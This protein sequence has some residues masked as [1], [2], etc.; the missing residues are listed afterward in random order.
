MAHL[1]ETW[2]NGV[3]D[4]DV[5]TASAIGPPENTTIKVWKNG[6]LL[7]TYVDTAGYATGN[8]G[9]GLDAGNPTDGANLGWRSYSVSASCPTSGT[10]PAVSIA[11]SPTSANVTASG[12]QTFTATV[13]NS[14]NTSVTWQVNGV[15]GGNSTVGTI[16]ASG[17]YSAPATPP[18]P[19]TVSVKA[20]SNAD[21]T[22]SATASI[23]ITATPAPTTG[24]VR[25]NWVAPSQE[26]DGSALDDLTGFRIYYGTGPNSLTNRIDVTNPSTRSWLISNLARGTWYFSLVAVSASGSESA[27]TTVIAHTF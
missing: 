15:T 6:T 7:L 9:I 16:S 25:I 17:V 22:K 1:K 23:T 20:I 11:I 13:S 4:G 19:A 27:R 24:S 12:T 26:T 8:P 3:N 21:P 14:S 18:S 10:T 2:L 5:F